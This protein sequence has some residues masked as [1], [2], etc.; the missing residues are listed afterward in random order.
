M[1]AILIIT[2]LFI[3]NNKGYKSRF[4]HFLDRDFYAEEHKNFEINYN[5]NNFDKRKNIFIVGNSYSKNQMENPCQQS[6]KK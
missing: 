6:I 4:H 5:Y 3:I 2:N 1:Y